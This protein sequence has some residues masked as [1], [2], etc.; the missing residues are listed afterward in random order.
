MQKTGFNWRSFISFNLFFSF[1]VMSVSGL[2]LYVAPPGRVFRWTD[3]HLFWLDL[4]QWQTLHTLFSYLFLGFALAHAFSMNWSVLFSYFTRKT[5]EGLRRKRELMAASVVIAS[6]VIGSLFT[7]QPFKA[8]MQLGDLTSAYWGKS[9]DNPPVAHAEEMTI[10]EIATVLLQITADDYAERIRKEGFK[11]N[12]TH[13]KLSEV[14]EI[15][16]VEPYRF[17]KKTTKGLQVLAIPAE[18]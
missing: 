16:K 7:I 10:A 14:C 17:F 2:V 15:N 5:A 6:F 12:D 11:L 3:W 9:I 18:K 1:L 13:Q 4:T 8:V